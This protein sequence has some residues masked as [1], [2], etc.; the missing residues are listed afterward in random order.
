M[1]ALGDAALARLRAGVD[2]PDLSG[3]R[4]RMVRP[5][6]RGGMGAVYLV[7]DVELQRE[8]ALKVLVPS[9]EESLA[10]RLRREA[11]V[12]AKLEHPSIVPI[13]DVG[14]LPDGRA[15]YAMK[16][17]RG[18]RLDEWLAAGRPRAEA[19][20]LFQRIAEAVAFAHA[21]GVVHRDLKPQN[22]MVGPFGEALVLDWGLAKEV[23]PVLPGSDSPMETGAGMVLGTP[24]FMAPEQARGEPISERTDVY[25]LGAMLYFLLTGRPPH[26]GETPAEALRSALHAEPP[27]PGA[28]PRPLLSILRK[29]MS[30]DPAARYQRAG[31][32]AA[33]VA[34]YLDGLP[35]SAHRETWWERGV[36]WLTKYQA[37]VVLLLA[38]LVMRALIALLVR[39]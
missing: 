7:E 24:A 34:A 14:T 18:E 39:K 33:D 4:Y 28:A 31:D 22:V 2:E 25:A 37:L 12:L 32:M 26:R 19:L 29:A 13:H 35:V 21:Q 20:R 30:R 8:V 11:R 15:Y 1:K 27:D 3:T 17:V 9:A 5:L 10:E 36:R 16:Y 38:Y 23:G 6:G